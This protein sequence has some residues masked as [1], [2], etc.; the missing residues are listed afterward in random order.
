MFIDKEKILRML[1]AT[2]AS[3]VVI[4]R[5]TVRIEDS[6]LISYMYQLYCYM[7][8]LSVIS[9]QIH[10]MTEFYPCLYQY[11]YW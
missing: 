2:S 11:R 4:L 5:V 7:Y 1:C 9:D 8:Q 10:D 3:K 6:Q